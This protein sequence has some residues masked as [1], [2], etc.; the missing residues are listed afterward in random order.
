M[1]IERINDDNTARAIAEEWDV[2][3]NMLA[4]MATRLPEAEAAGVGVAI[5]TKRGEMKP[6]GKFVFV[7]ISYFAGFIEGQNGWFVVRW[8][9]ATWEDLPVIAE[10]L[11]KAEELMPGAVNNASAEQKMDKYRKDKQ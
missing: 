4:A 7:L 3:E 10:H 8:T 11:I 2:C 5:M 6:D 9:E 1:R